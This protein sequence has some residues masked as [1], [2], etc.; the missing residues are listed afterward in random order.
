MCDWES[1]KLVSENVGYYILRI[2]S[3]L[4]YTIDMNP[5][6]YRQIPQIYHGN[7]SGGNYLPTIMIMMMKIMIMIRM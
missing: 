7:Y 3:G 5:N 6:I 2:I 4:L 1:R